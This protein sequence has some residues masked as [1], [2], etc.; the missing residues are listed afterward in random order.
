MIAKTTYLQRLVQGDLAVVFYLSIINLLI[1]LVLNIQGG[2]GLFRDEYYYLACADNL[3]IGYVDH[4]PF[5]VY[6]LKLTTLLFGDSIFA[7]RLIPALCGALTVFFTGL[8]AFRMGGNRIA[9]TM[10]CLFS[11]SPINLVMFSFYSMNALEILTWTLITYFVLRIIQEEKPSLWIILGIVLGLGLMNKIGVLFIGAGLFIGLLLTKHRKWFAT[12]WPYIA[13]IITFLL[14]LPYIIWNVQNDMAHLE[15]IH[16]ASSGKYSSLSAVDFLAGQLLINQPIGVLVWIPG[17]L[18]LFFNKELKQYKLLGFLF[19]VPLLIFTFNGTSKAEYLAP[20]YTIVWAAGG[21]WW[22][23]RFQS[24]NVYRYLSY[25]F[26]ILWG[27]THILLIPL[28]LPVLP[29]EKYIAYADTIGMKPSSS[30]AKEL[31][32]LPQFYAD[33]FGW[34]EKAEGVAAVYHALPA[35]DKEICGIYATNYGRCASID[36]FSDEY[37]LPKTIGNHNNYW[38]WGP[39]Q[40]TGEVMIMLGGE[41]DDYQDDFE[42]VSLADTVDCKYCMPYEDNLKIFV[43]RKLK[44]EFSTVWA[45]IKHFE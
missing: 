8:I 31:A 42:E 2:Y 3:A 4:P 44:S 6:V 17:L 40:Y 28:V 24:A 27:I 30:E 35:E 25:G 12:P 38:I 41:A 37:N 34:K 9:I 26:I 32:E 16:N 5:S 39:R 45:G 10:A 11:F 15:F 22:G 36:Y 43:C 20:A 19:L 7:V 23:K 29:V 18:G 14:F 1:H 21:V 13:G 33:M